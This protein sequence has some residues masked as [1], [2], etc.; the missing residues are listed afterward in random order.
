LASTRTGAVN[1]PLVTDPFTESFK[2]HW[3][4]TVRERVGVA[5]GQWLFFASGGAAFAK[6]TF[7]DSLSFPGSGTTSAATS[8][9][10]ITGWTAGGGVEWLFL[11]HWSLKAEYLHVDFGRRS[12]T[13]FNSDPVRFPNSTIVHSHTLTEEIGRVGVNYHF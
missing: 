7:S 8:S 2:S 4:A 11:P 10:T 9:G 6:P 1:L 5:S 3:L 12:F 13:S